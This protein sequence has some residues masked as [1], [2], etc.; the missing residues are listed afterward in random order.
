MEY[1]KPPDYK[2]NG[3]IWS[4]GG[5]AWASYSVRGNKPE[6]KKNLDEAIAGATAA[7]WE[8]ASTIPR[9]L[10]DEIRIIRLD[11]LSQLR[12][13][14]SE[15]MDGIECFVVVGYF[16]SGGE[17][18][19]WIGRSDHLIRRL[20]ERSETMKREEVRTQIVVN[21]DIPDSRFSQAG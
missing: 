11:E 20:E 18:K 3:V 19:V 13:L 4:D 5:S 1:N 16:P 14:A 17:C 6:T 2:Q 10:T 9:L 7:S 12:M 8:T 15:R 21:Q